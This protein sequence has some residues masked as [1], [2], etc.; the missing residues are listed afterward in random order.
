MLSNNYRKIDY[1]RGREREKRKHQAIIIISRKNR[2]LTFILFVG[3]PLFIF[4]NSIEFEW[5]SSIYK[6]RLKRKK[7]NEKIELFCVYLFSLKNCVWQ[8]REGKLISKFFIFFLFFSS[9][10]SCFILWKKM[11]CVVFIPVSVWFFFI[12]YFH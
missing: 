2:K 9:L 7:K 12:F 8:I 4:S 3:E 6:Q 5:I 11:L 10:N 1:K